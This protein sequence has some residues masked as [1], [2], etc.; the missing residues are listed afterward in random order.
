MKPDG[1]RFA[2]VGYSKEQRQIE[3]L[4]PYGTKV[5][6]LAKTIDF[7]ARDVFSKLPR[8]CTPCTSGDHFI[9]RERLENVIKVDLDKQ[10]IVR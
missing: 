9:I 7:L 1:E 6:D 4:V 8:G 5:A 3:L 2:E 10:V